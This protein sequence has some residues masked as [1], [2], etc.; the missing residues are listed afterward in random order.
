M[1]EKAR[2]IQTFKRVDYGHA[3]HTFTLDDPK[4]YTKPWTIVENWTLK[5]NIRIMEYSCEEGNRDLL[6]G[7][8]K[9]WHPPVE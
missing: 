8:I 1:S 9:P 2:I 3:E 4:T 6:D 7:H 5:P